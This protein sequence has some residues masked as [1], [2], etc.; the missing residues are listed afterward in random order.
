MTFLVTGI[1]LTVV[2]MLSYLSISHTLLAISTKKHQNQ[3]GLLSLQFPQLD[4]KLQ[5]SFEQ[6]DIYIIGDFENGCST[7]TVEVYDPLSDNW[8]TVVPLSQSIDH[9]AAAAAASYDEKVYVVG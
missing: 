5:A 7:S 4:L 1:L 6:Q 3:S 2:T 8:S 9:A